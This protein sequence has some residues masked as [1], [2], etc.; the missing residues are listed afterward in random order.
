M[1]IG[2]IIELDKY[3]INLKSR[4]SSTESRCCYLKTPIDFLEFYKILTESSTRIISTADTKR[5]RHVNVLTSDMVDVHFRR[6]TAQLDTTVSVSSLAQP[7]AVVVNERII[8]LQAINN[9]VLLSSSIS[10]WRQCN[11]TESSGK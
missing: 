3:V 11:I 5:A 1:C 9:T 4:F 8:L 2:F 10:C 6:R 7:L